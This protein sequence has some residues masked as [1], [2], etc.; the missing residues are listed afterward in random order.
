MCE[1]VAA[2]WP[3]PRPLRPLLERALEIE[4]FGIDGFGWGVAWL[5]VDDPGRGPRVRGYRSVDSLADD[6]AGRAEVGGVQSPRFIVHM[7]R[8]TLLSTVDLADTQPFVADDGEFAFAHNGR[9][10]HHERFRSR[11]ADRLAGRADSEIGFRVFEAH[12]RRGMPAA[13]A[14][15]RTLDDLGGYGNFAYLGADGEL[16]ARGGHGLNPFW[17]FELDRG[18]VAS[19]ACHSEDDSV[20]RLV[21]TDARSPVPVAATAEVVA[22]ASITAT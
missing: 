12:T 2:A 15:H 11:H 21:F 6:D 5:D 14:L 20:F 18:I 10:D 8:P 7:R 3:E 16:V 22:G 9:F 17:R 4:R 1:I 19:T 13:D